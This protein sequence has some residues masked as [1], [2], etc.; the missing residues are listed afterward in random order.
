M[1]TNAVTILE[2]EKEMRKMEKE[3]KIEKGRKKD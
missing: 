1:N 3:M 2:Y